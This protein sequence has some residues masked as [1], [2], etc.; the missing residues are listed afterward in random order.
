MSYCNKHNIS[1]LCIYCAIEKQTADI[2][3]AIIDSNAPKNE[4]V[5]DDTCIELW[6]LFWIVVVLSIT[7]VTLAREGYILN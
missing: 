3:K 1:E 2:T 7:I 4:T 6:P 5:V